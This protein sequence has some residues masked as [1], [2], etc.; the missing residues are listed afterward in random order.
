[1]SV[2]HSSS[3]F[4]KAM[5][6]CSG[7]RTKPVI[8]KN[9][10][11]QTWCDIEVLQ[12][13]LLIQC[14]KS[15]FVNIVWLTAV[16]HTFCF[17]KLRSLPQVNVRYFFCLFWLEEMADMWYNGMVRKDKSEFTGAFYG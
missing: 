11:D 17:A 5:A 6:L 14:V 15:G 12:K 4:W 3:V 16:S 7:K 2:W 10:T 13:P 8:I 1:M 9:A